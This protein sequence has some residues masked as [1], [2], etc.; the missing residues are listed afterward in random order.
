MAV[1]GLVAGPLAVHMPAPTA[2][3]SHLRKDPRELRLER[4]FESK[5]SPAKAFARDFV[6]AADQ[7]NL[8]WRL[9]PSLAF[10][11]SGGGKAFKNNNMFGWQNGDHRFRSV[12]DS[13]HRVAERLANSHYYRD[14]DLDQLLYTYNP[15]P[16]YTER[17]RWVME[18]L[19]P[20]RATRPVRLGASSHLS[21]PS[22]R[23]E[24]WRHH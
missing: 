11:E 21:Q 12:K 3:F 23:G 13:I 19:G 18:D 20:A 16:G 15:I 10:V 1:L 14:K 9:L 22:R 4:Y 24:G 5:N 17:V 8:D 7:H 2:D 6:R